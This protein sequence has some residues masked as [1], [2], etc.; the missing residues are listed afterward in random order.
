MRTDG[1]RWTVDRK[2]WT[3]VRRLPS[4]INRL[5]S[6]A[7]RR[8]ATDHGPR[9]TI[10]RPLS[11]PAVLLDESLLRGLERL[12][13]VTANRQA[14]RVGG[15]RRSAR[16]APAAEFVEH[17]AYSPGD[18]LR[19]VDWHVYARLGI[20]VVRLGELPASA[21]VRLLVDCSRSMDWG[22]PNKLVRARQLA[23]GIGYVALCQ[24]D[25]VA[26]EPLG[27]GIG[28]QGNSYS[29][30]PD[31]RSLISPFVGG[32]TQAHRLFAALQ[33][34][35]PGRDA[36]SGKP[37]SG[38]RGQRDPHSHLPD[39]GSLIPPSDAGRQL[40]ERMQVYRPG[41]LAVLISDLLVPDGY[42]D[43]IRALQAR[44]VEVRVVHVLAPQELRPE[45]A[46]DCDLVDVETGERRELTLEGSTLTHYRQRLDAW[47]ADSE[48]FC[49]GRGIPYARVDTA[50]P[51]D[52]VLLGDLRRQGVFA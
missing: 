7:H 33:H 31:P 38:I 32:K 2:G 1:G 41:D 23:G 12:A 14:R 40:A 30:I 44:G 39:S 26:V 21:T 48:S 50:R 5:S 6:I 4:L 18:D 22:R 51:L 46:G 24:L 37:E 29:L 8:S 19:R 28:D 47:L 49:A 9:S 25:R 43:G 13:L 11:G 16:R 45:L 17:R 27:G 36:G 42:R 3:A 52:Q 15:E 35:G 34:V 20:P 10:H